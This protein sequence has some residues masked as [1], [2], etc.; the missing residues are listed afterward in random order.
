RRDSFLVSWTGNAMRLATRLIARVLQIAGV[1]I[2]AYGAFVFV[3]AQAFQAYSKRAFERN[4]A[5]P[6]VSVDIPSAGLPTP[7]PEQVPRR[8]SILPPKELDSLIGRIE[9]P[10]LK[11]STMIL[12][13][14][15]DR[16]LSLGAAHV[17]GTGMPGEAGN[18]VIAAHRDTFF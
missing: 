14:D 18:V 9:V 6:Y 4:L 7:Q 1:L 3:R 8:A 11:L 17:P 12:E 16:Q 2:L 10:R 5:T 15:G 13:G